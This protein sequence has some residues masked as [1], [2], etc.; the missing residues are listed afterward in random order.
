MC[1][2]I[3]FSSDIL[4]AVKYINGLYEHIAGE[5]L[6]LC[7]LRF[8]PGRIVYVKLTEREYKVLLWVDFFTGYQERAKYKRGIP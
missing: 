1:I 4:G 5:P 7:S 3:C 6:S 2:Y 8:N